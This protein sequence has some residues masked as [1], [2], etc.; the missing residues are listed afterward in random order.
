MYNASIITQITVLI[1]NAYWIQ[2][3]TH[4]LWSV[5]KFNVTFS[6]GIW[7]IIKNIHTL[8]AKLNTEANKLKYL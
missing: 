3:Y 2:S 6:K 8:A 7:I 1:N 4:M 5:I